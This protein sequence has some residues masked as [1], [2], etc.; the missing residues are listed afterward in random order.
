LARIEESIEIN[1]TPQRIWPIVRWN[2]VPE[3]MSIIKRVE[4][5]SEETERV[6]AT[7]HWIAEAEGVE[8]AWDAETTEWEQYKR[9]AWRTTG[10]AFTG[11]GSMTLT[12]TESG[13]TATLL[14]DYELPCSI[15]GRI[16]D[17]RHLCRAIENGAKNGLKKLKEIA[18]RR[19]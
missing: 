13:T 11:I 1:A 3:W 14:M 18:E 7:A 9:G 16:I 17:K 19:R 5:T 8:S 2:K 10:G 12:Q 15:A 6:G 4:Y